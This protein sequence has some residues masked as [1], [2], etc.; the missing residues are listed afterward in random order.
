MSL[1]VNAKTYANDVSRSPD[2]FRYLGPVHDGDSNDTI[3]LYRTAAKPTATYSGNTRSRAKLTRAVTDGTAQIG[4]M[5]LDVSVSV[6]VGAVSAQVDSV[7]NDLAAWLATTA[8][9]NLIKSHI[10]NQ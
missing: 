3:D 9:K 6:P 4:D 7:I 8:A 5:I 1:T 2:S 10:I